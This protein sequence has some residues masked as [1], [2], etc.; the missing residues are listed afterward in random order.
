MGE[1][2]VMVGRNHT[3]IGVTTGKEKAGFSIK[4]CH[5]ADCTKGDFLSLADRNG[6]KR[7]LL[8]SPTRK[9][10]VLYQNWKNGT[11]A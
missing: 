3:E 8:K 6:I 4:P 2:E 10:R 9:D 11:N 7:Q 5:T 1:K